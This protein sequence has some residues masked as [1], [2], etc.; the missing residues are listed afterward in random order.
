MMPQTAPIISS[1][2]VPLD[3]TAHQGLVMHFARRYRLPDLE[4]DDLVQEGFIGLLQAARR[5][6]PAQGAFS[7]YAAYWITKYLRQVYAAARLQQDVLPLPDTLPDPRAAAQGL[8]TPPPLS[9]R[10]QHW[11][12]GLDAEERRVLELRYGLTGEGC[13]TVRA[14]AQVL[15]CSKTRLQQTAHRALDRLRQMMESE[16]C[17]RPCGE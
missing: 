2:P 6:D 14:A 11:L 15:G 3:I 1:S 10:L 13:Y 16:S 8:S 7:T 4:L 17:E 5:Y 12:A 9:P